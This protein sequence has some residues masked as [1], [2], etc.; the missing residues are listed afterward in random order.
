MVA[1]GGSDCGP[2]LTMRKKGARDYY[3]ERQAKGSRRF[4]SSS[5]QGPSRV[6]RRIR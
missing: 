1:S 3:A 6:H 4:D 5:I 2:Q